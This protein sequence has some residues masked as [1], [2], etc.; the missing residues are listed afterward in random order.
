MRCFKIKL[1][2][3]SLVRA[4]ELKRS[5]PTRYPELGFMH[6]KITSISRYKSVWCNK[7]HYYQ[8]SALSR[9]IDLPKHNIRL[10]LIWLFYCC[11]LYIKKNPFRK[12]EA[13]ESGR[14]K[15]I[16]LILINREKNRHEE[17]T[18]ARLFSF[19]KWA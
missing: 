4:C 9:L 16:N 1:H 13:Y 15:K 2:E 5:H 6:K 12:S 11:P 18:I 10:F 14:F 3:F 8:R 17:Y 7:Q 19:E